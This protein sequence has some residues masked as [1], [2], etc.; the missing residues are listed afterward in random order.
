[1]E[2][3]LYS[4]L[5]LLIVDWVDSH[6]VA[7]SAVQIIGWTHFMGINGQETHMKAIIQPLVGNLDASALLKHSNTLAELA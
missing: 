5:N 6:I 2:I 4:P 3:R 7:V 1:M